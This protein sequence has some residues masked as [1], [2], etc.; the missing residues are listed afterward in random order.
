[1][2]LIEHKAPHL[3]R[4]DAYRD[5]CWSVDAW[6]F[7]QPAS[8]IYLCFEAF[9]DMCLKYGLRLVYSKHG[10]N[11]GYSGEFFPWKYEKDQTQ[12]QVLKNYCGLII[13]IEDMGTANEIKTALSNGRNVIALLP[14]ELIGC[15]YSGN[16]TRIEKAIEGAKELKINKSEEKIRPTLANG[17][18]VWFEEINTDTKGR[19]FVTRDAFLSD[20]Y[21]MEGYGKSDENLSKIKS[22]INE[23]SSFKYPLLRAEIRNNP[24][25]WLTHEPL[26]LIFDVINH[27]PTIDYAEISIAFPENFEPV[28]S[29]ERV[30]NNLGTLK[31]IS[32]AFQVIPRTDGI[33]KNFVDIKI[34]LA[35]GDFIPLYFQPIDIDITPSYGNALR[36]QNKQ[37]D[38][39]LSRLISISKQAN[40]SE[41]VK[42]LPELMKLDAR[43]CLN[44]I[45]SLAEK[46]CVLLLNKRKIRLFDSTF[47]SV[48]QALQQNKILSSKSV[49]Y[50]HT[51]RVIGNLASH[52]TDENFSDIDVRLVSYAFSCVV[53]EI[54]EQKLI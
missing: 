51:I 13:R 17:D 30:I 44:K 35:N 27:G 4:E 12:V 33:Y 28:G 42:V 10:I 40:L 29:I 34:K 48:I 2:L 38:Q 19:L 45:R 25:I 24:S 23:F 26:S 7:Y 49:G 31:K 47:V 22:L 3:Y 53:E 9:S 11:K 37:D 46:L 41:E 43:A 32:F 14:N 39:S 52:P 15:W 36:K 18:P 5:Y 1:M 54:V 20:G 21:F 6:G 50:L 16:K 8:F